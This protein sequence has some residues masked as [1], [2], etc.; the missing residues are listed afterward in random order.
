M[1]PV[2][3]LDTGPLVAYLSNDEAQHNWAVTEIERLEPPLLTC[4][5]VLTEAFFLLKSVSGGTEALLELLRRSSIMVPFAIMDELAEVARLMTKYRDL[6]M[7]L[8]DACLVR[9]AEL[10]PGAK[11]VTLDD[12]FTIY[13]KHGRQAIP[14]LMPAVE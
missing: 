11:V 6:P 5:A 12:H 7:S 1:K 14:T 9:M 8:A 10:N 2:V 13:R 4:E 3:L